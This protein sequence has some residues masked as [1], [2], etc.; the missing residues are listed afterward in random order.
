MIPFIRHVFRQ[1]LLSKRRQAGGVALGSPAVPLFDTTCVKCSLFS[2]IW[3]SIN[4]HFLY[5]KK[6][7][8]RKVFDLLASYVMHVFVEYKIIFV[9]V[10]CIWFY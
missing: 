4:K 8:N 10:I 1:G 3:I 7:S 6:P 2:S 5:K 9:M